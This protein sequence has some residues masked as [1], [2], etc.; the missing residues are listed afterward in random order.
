[1]ATS[2]T[3]GFEGHFLLSLTQTDKLS[4]KSTLFGIIKIGAI[5]K[6]HFLFIRPGW[7]IKAS[8]KKWIKD[9]SR[10]MSI[11]FPIIILTSL[12][13]R[14]SI[15]HSAQLIDWPNR[16][17][18]ELISK[19]EKKQKRGIFWFGLSL[20]FYPGN[21]LKQEVIFKNNSFF[22]S[23]YCCCCLIWKEGKN[24]KRKKEEKKKR[25]RPEFR[26]IIIIKD[27]LH[28]G[29]WFWKEWDRANWWWTEF[30]LIN[31]SDAAESDASY[32]YGLSRMSFNTHYNWRIHKTRSLLT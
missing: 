13:S 18:G 11:W 10:K 20:L 2:Q 27:I 21:L 12:L 4:G 25:G 28:S 8:A 14:F 29:L 3:F 30:Q 6:I 22:L 15:S 32:S 9:I 5:L 23:R 19:F 7:P 16:F 31:N 1:M 17:V 26:P 24:I